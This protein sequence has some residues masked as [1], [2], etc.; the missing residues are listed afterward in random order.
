MSDEHTKFYLPTRFK[1]EIWRPC[2]NKPLLHFTKSL[3]RD[4][5]E[6]ICLQ[7]ADEHTLVTAKFEPPS[8]T[9][10][11]RVSKYQTSLTLHKIIQA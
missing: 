7:M 4:N 9:L 8:M 11:Y 3:K 6:T 5:I 1:T 2:S 10:R